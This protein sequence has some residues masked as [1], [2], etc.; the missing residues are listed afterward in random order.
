M[1]MCPVK[2]SFQKVHFLLANAFGLLP[3]LSD[4]KG[5][6]YQMWIVLSTYNGAG[7]SS[8]VTSP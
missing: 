8:F 7:K 5:L 3:F 2:N 6:A 4:A 1:S